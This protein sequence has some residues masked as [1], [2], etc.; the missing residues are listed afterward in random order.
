MLIS[1]QSKLDQRLKIELRSMGPSTQISF[2]TRLPTV[3][4]A[5]H[6]AGRPAGTNQ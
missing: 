4:M 6:C 1:F 2:E 5:A 3:L